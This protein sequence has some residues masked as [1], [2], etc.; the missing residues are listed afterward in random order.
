MGGGDSSF[1]EGSFLPRFFRL[2][3]ELRAPA[4]PAAGGAHRVPGVALHADHLV[5]AATLGL[6]EAGH[7]E[8]E[9]G[10]V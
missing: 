3:T 2:R 10:L 7:M 5:Q 1:R 8:G 4:L 9:R 6:G